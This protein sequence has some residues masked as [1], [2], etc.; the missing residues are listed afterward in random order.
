[1]ALTE[2]WALIWRNM[3]IKWTE[4]DHCE[5]SVSSELTLGVNFKLTQC[6]LATIFLHSDWFN[7]YKVLHIVHRAWKNINFLASNPP[8]LNTV[9]MFLCKKRH[10]FP[11]NSKISLQIPTFP[12]KELPKFPTFPHCSCALLDSLYVCFVNISSTHYIQP[13][14]LRVRTVSKKTCEIAHV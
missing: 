11:P 14:C 7:I 1:M 13:V 4:S 8:N 3:V 9:Y 2:V 12:S 6:K 10:N 5:C